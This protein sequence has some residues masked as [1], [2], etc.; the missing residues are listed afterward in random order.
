MCH[1]NWV[2]RG[3]GTKV[4]DLHAVFACSACHDV[5]D[6]RVPMPGHLDAAYVRDAMVRA[7]C[8]TQSRWVQMGLLSVKGGKTL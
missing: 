3:V 7:L 8:E 5:I 4:S 6:R 1:Q 2:G